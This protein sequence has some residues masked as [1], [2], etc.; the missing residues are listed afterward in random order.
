MTE[1]VITTSLTQRPLYACRADDPLIREVRAYV[2]RLR[3][4]AAE[5]RELADKYDRLA[6]NSEPVP[7]VVEPGYIGE[8]APVGD[9]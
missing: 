1:Y 7:V 6:D 2:A 8:K 9:A 4:Q 5:Y 3:A